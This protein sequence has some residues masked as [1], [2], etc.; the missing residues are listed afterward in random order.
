MGLFLFSIIATLSGES[1]PAVEERIE[2]LGDEAKAD[3]PHLGQK[4]I[5]ARMRI[6][7]YRGNGTRSFQ[8]DGSSLFPQ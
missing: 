6:L 8:G 3:C 5:L 1:G 2:V 7:G 4:I